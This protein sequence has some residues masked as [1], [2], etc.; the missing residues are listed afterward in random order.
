M[1]IAGGDIL[2]I[3]TAEGCQDRAWMDSPLEALCR[4][5]LR[6]R[7]FWSDLPRV[8]SHAPTLEERECAL[9]F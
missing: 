1:Q 4:A 3:L 7:Q 8:A 5:L 6:T 2:T 9:W